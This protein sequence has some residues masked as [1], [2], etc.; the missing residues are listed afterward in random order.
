[1][2]LANEADLVNVLW[3]LDTSTSNHMMGDRSIFAE[4]DQTI[5]G[6]VRFGDNWIVDIRG[7]GT[8]MFTMRGDEHRALTDVYFIPRLKT[9]I[10]NL[11]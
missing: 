7:Y 4:L 10:V 2:R 5:I 1:M 6:S 3:H 8:I 11:D 9:S